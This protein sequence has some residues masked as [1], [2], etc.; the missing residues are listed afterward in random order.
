WLDIM[1]RER[2]EQK[3]DEA[4]RLL[5]ISEG[6]V[7]WV[8]AVMTARAFGKPLNSPGME[9]LARRLPWRAMSRRNW[10]QAEFDQLVQCM[11]GLSDAKADEHVFRLWALT[12]LDRS[13]WKW[14]RMRPAS[15]PLI[16]IRQWSWWIWHRIVQRDIEISALMNQADCDWR[17]SG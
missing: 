17:I 2:L 3:S 5:E 9:E 16:R 8:E 4:M 14:G 13:W 15:F 11:S 10:F 1:S 12:S 7:D 6:N